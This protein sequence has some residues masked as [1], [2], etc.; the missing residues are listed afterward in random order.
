MAHSA[1]LAHRGL[2][3]TLPVLNQDSIV[4]DAI[5][6]AKVC[7]VP[8]VNHLRCLHFTKLQLIRRLLRDGCEDH[9]VKPF[10]FHGPSGERLVAEN[11]G[12]EGF[13]FAQRKFEQTFGKAASV[14]LHQFYS[15]YLNHVLQGE[16]LGRSLLAQIQEISKSKDSAEAKHDLLVE[17]TRQKTEAWR[18][19]V[20]N[21]DS[22]LWARHVRAYQVFPRTFNLQGF[23]EAYDIQSSE[24]TSG[25]FFRDI[26]HADFQA[27]RRS[28]FS[29]LRCMGT[30]PIGAVNA[31]GTGGGSP[32]SIKSHVVD[33]I[34]GSRHQVLRAFDR[35]AEHGLLSIFEVIPNHTSCDAKLLQANPSL[36]VHTRTAP[37]DSTGYFHYEHPE[38]GEFWIRHGG[39]KDLGTGKRSFW[40][41]TLQLDFSKPETREFVISEI[42][43]LIKQYN[44]DGIRVDSAYQMLNDYLSKNW[45]GELAHPLPR[46]E[47]LEELVLRVKSDCPHVAIM[48][49]AF[50]GFDKL[51]ECGVDLLY[52]MSRM[53]RNGGHIHEGWHE[54][55]VSRNP[56]QIRAA[57]DRAQF[58]SWQVG[59]PDILTFF[60]HQ[61]FPSPE[62]QFGDA[63]KWGAAVLSI[64]RPG[65]FSFY[66]G[67][68]AGFEAPCKEDHKMITFNEPVQID[69]SGSTE[70]FSQFQ[71]RLLLF[72]GSVRESLGEQTTMETLHPTSREHSAPWVGYLIRSSLPDR[73][74]KIAV[75]VNPS[76]Q[77]TTAQFLDPDSGKRISFEI[78]PA[79]P[80][81]FEIVQIHGTSPVPEY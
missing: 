66:A 63:W 28:S 5:I 60:G 75:V 41:D 50:D 67:T 81:G 30:F 54:A 69:W 26:T 35:A 16:E 55:L 61:D 1:A 25:G 79:G 21:L 42:L 65:A 6:S 13:I 53:I 57:I 71:R 58:L 45:E 12:L 59:G 73:D 74:L 8:A 38:F 27:L 36:Y 43:D 32:Y 44:L 51:A 46:R 17:L 70:D 2:D 33:S 76:S 80:T 11:S 14:A 72:A 47:F 24:P 23:R 15:M 18:N 19:E 4:S 31:K 68:E 49:E 48:A 7:S 9:Q 56:D 77:P 40:V 29:A 64:L 39:Y 20:R 34:H 52:G 22:S 3:Q 62:R 10:I 78:D 37:S